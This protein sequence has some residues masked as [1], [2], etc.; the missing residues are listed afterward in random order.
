MAV[1]NTQLRDLLKAQHTERMDELVQIKLHLATL[2]G[3]TAENTKD[4]GELARAVAELPCKDRGERIAVVETVVGMQP[5]PREA[6]RLEATTE[7][8]S[9][10]WGRVWGVVALVL[11]VLLTAL[12][13]ALVSGA[14]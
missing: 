14:I 1:T 13:G 5:N 8:H 7:A 2:N 11:G 3:T 9:V 4:I 12:V 6:G 10:N